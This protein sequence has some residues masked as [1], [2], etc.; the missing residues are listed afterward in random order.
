MYTYICIYV[1]MYICIYIHIY[2]Y[3]VFFLFLCK[4]HTIIAA[5]VGAYVF[6]GTPYVGT[7]VFACLA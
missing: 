2:I 7:Y 1:Y 6:S 5:Y 3:D 4:F